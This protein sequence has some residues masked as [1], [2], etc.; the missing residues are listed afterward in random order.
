MT[1]AEGTEFKVEHVDIKEDH[2]ESVQVKEEPKIKTEEKDEPDVETC[3][4][5]IEPE[6]DIYSEGEEWKPPPDLPTLTE[7][8][9]SESSGERELRRKRKRCR[10]KLRKDDK[11][12]GEKPQLPLLSCYICGKMNRTAYAQLRHLTE[13]YENRGS[14]TAHEYPC[15]VLPCGRIFTARKF[16]EGHKRLHEV[17]KLFDCKVCSR[18]FSSDRILQIHRRVHEIEKEFNCEICTESFVYENAL[19]IHVE[20][21]ISKHPFSRELLD[22]HVMPTFEGNSRANPNV[23]QELLTGGILF[24][25]SQCP[26]RFATFNDRRNHQNR[27]HPKMM[28]CEVCGKVLR[29]PFAHRL[30]MV[31]HTKEKPFKCKFCDEAFRNPNTLVNHR[32]T[33]HGM[34]NQNRIYRPHQCET[35][36]KSYCKKFSLNEHINSKHKGIKL[37]CDLCG[38]SYGTKSRLKIH[39]QKVHLNEDEKP[40]KVPKAPRVSKLS[41]AV[42]IPKCPECGFLASTKK[43]LRKHRMTDHYNNLHCEECNITMDNI[44]LYRT[45]AEDHK[46]GI[47][48]VSGPGRHGQIYGCL[49][50]D[51]FYT[52]RRFLREHINMTHNSITFTCDHCE[53]IFQTKRAMVRHLSSTHGVEEKQPQPRKVQGLKAKKP[54]KMKIKFPPPS[55]TS[56]QSSHHY[57]MEPPQSS[58]LA[59]QIP[60]QSPVTIVAA[61]PHAHVTPPPH[62][63]QQQFKV[64]PQL[65]Y[66]HFGNM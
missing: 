48:V 52:D 27:D 10:Q 35:C 42:K 65:Q 32:R 20:E 37:I 24:K 12:T 39:F 28:A 29:G 33:V 45:H 11:E 51:K 5:A 60:H 50:C 44:L 54:K 16:L 15:E 57:Q 18:S 23:D 43:G 53:M 17:E 25:C 30:H 26:R 49:R 46:D 55:E 34:G 64:E 56:S 58:P 31:I 62:E 66:I 61:N 4:L 22:I 2:E 13:H 6:M 59:L 19:I 21:H 36:G 8:N 47:S 1:D 14:I 63:I 7:G 38:K 3:F 40:L 9:V 41:K